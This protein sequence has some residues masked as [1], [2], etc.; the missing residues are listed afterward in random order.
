MRIGSKTYLYLLRAKYNSTL[1]SLI[2]E[3]SYI[4]NLILVLTT[5]SLIGLKQTLITTYNNITN[6][7]IF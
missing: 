1:G 4:I 7:E 5:Y 2:G 3:N 6:L